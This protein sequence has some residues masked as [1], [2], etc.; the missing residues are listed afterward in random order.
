MGSLF[1]KRFTVSFHTLPRTKSEQRGDIQPPPLFLLIVLFYIYFGQTL[2]DL[3]FENEF[4]ALSTWDKLLTRF[5]DITDETG[6]EDDVYRYKAAVLYVRQYL[7]SENECDP[8]QLAF[9]YFEKSLLEMGVQ[10]GLSWRVEGDCRPGCSNI[11]SILQTW[12]QSVYW[13]INYDTT[14][15]E[16]TFVPWGVLRQSEVFRQI[17]KFSPS[18]GSHDRIIGN[19][20]RRVVVSL[21]RKLKD[22]GRVRALIF[23]ISIAVRPLWRH[24]YRDGFGHWFPITFRLW[25]ERDHRSRVHSF[26]CLSVLKNACFIPSSSI[27]KVDLETSHSFTT[28]P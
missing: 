3:I 17:P 21:V 11:R 28:V 20:D 16:T 5:W 7:F 4:L 6:H 8:L 22:H 26:H 19:I 27:W 18:R 23:L 15:I 2:K 9:D 14:A 10:I 12:L 13:R 25:W 24:R 1:T